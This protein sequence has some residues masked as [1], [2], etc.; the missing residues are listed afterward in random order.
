M[1]ALHAVLVLTPCKRFRPFVLW[2]G[3]KGDKQ[4]MPVVALT[5]LSDSACR[6]EVASAE[7]TTGNPHLHQ[8]VTTTCRERMRSLSQAAMAGHVM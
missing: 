8:I 7:M 6:T 1:C 4:Q 5:K 2:L 3:W